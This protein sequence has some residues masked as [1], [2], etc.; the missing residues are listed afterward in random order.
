MTKSIENLPILYS[1]KRC[2]YA[3]RAR[4]ALGYAKIDHIHREID[5]KNKHPD[6]LKTS[7]KGTVPVLIDPKRQQVID[8]S[9]DIVRYALTEHQPKDWLPV[10]VI[11]QEDNTKLFDDMMQTFVPAVRKI[12]YGTTQNEDH[13]AIDT[14]RWFLDRIETKLSGQH[15][16]LNG[17][18]AL[19]ILCFPNIRQL[20][21]HDKDWLSHH[22]LIGVANWINF[23]CES[24][25][26]KT[27]FV[28]QLTWNTDQSPII[29]KHK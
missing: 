19:D 8:E 5:L 12:K 2:P 4:M 18:S 13:E 21:I 15:H 7:P 28:N 3:I 10:S 14:A 17:P 23:W 20:A 24:D 1:F 9:L 6:F 26:F 29:V 25:V 27:I 16:L 22:Q 11:D